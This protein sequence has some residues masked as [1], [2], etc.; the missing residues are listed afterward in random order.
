MQIDTIAAYIN[1]NA[2]AIVNNLEPESLAVYAFLQ[3]EFTTTNVAENH[4][5]Q[6]LYR[7]FYRL[8]NAGLT[9]EFKTEYFRIMQEEKGNTT[10][11]ISSI[12]RSLYSF[13]N[14]KGQE[15]FQFSFVTK[16]L[17]TLDHSFPIY[18]SEVARV[19]GF[20]RPYHSGFDAKLSA[21]LHQ[22]QSIK[23]AYEQ[24]LSSNLLSPTLLEFDLRFTGHQLPEIKQ[25]DFIFWSAGKIMRKAPETESI[26]L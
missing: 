2:T 21:Y 22:F 3:K 26:L 9:P 14:R 20:S 5:F 8:D 25:L 1:G 15:S 6:F 17:N 11:D 12:L 10:H 24:M 16:L 19:F 23:Q 4:L 7:S 13:R 18:D